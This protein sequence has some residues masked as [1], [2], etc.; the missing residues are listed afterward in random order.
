M[1]QCPKCSSLTISEWRLFIASPAGLQECSNCRSVVRFKRD[2]KVLLSAAP[3][4]VCL[5][6]LPR[7]SFELPLWLGLFWILMAGALSALLAAKVVEFEL[8]PK[9]PSFPPPSA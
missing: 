7:L 2:W 5:L 9:Q 3:L 6:V 8:A 1:H 4:V